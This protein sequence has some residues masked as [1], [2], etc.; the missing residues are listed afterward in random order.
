MSRKQEDSKVATVRIDPMNYP[1]KR[2][3]RLWFLMME[4]SVI[5][6]DRPEGQLALEMAKELERR[7]DYGTAS[8]KD[9]EIFYKMYEAFRVEPTEH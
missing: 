5:A 9:K 7:V 2:G 8:E 6:T 4:S 3:A 1:S